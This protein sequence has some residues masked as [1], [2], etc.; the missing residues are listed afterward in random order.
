[1]PTPNCLCCS[2]CVAAYVSG[3][4][5]IAAEQGLHCLHVCILS[6]S[7]NMQLVH[8][9]CQDH[10]T[11]NSDNLSLLAR[12][13]PKTHYLSQVQQTGCDFTLSRAAPSELVPCQQ[14]TAH[15]GHS[16][17]LM[18][19]GTWDMCFSKPLPLLLLLDAFVELQS[20]LD[21]ML[22][23]GLQTRSLF[24]CCGGDIL[25]LI[26][27][28]NLCPAPVLWSFMVQFYLLQPLQGPQ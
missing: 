21:C 27:I 25:V 16:T 3:L 12:V 22:L 7:N 18:C 10:K 5:G 14:L 26:L 19:P 23:L 15:Q 11:S 2:I 9:S 8:V 6:V 17:C 13:V 24:C 1:M 28:G 4:Q 20:I